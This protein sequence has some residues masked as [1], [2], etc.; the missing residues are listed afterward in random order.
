[1]LLSK[2]TLKQLQLMRFKKLQTLYRKVLLSLRILSRKALLLLKSKMKMK[3]HWWVL[4]KMPHQNR[5]IVKLKM[6]LNLKY[7]CLHWMYKTFNWSILMK[8][9]KQQKFWMTT[10]KIWGTTKLTMRILTIRRI[11]WRIDCFISMTKNQ[12]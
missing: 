11:S 8:N 7:K 10:S 4:M 3:I 12:S 6:F 9:F 1:M 2:L 5:K